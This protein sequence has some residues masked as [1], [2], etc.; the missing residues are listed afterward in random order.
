MN[1]WRVGFVCWAVFV[2]AVPG[3]ACV[4]T[5]VSGKHEKQITGEAVKLIMG[6]FAQHGEAYWAGQLKYNTELLK[7]EPGNPEH[8]NDLAVALLKLKRYDEA[9]AEFEKIEVANPGRYKT[10][11]NLG[12]LYK[13]T[14]DFQKAAEYTRKALE[15]KP[16][17]HLGLGDYYLQMLAW[18]A[19]VASDPG[20]DPA[21]N[22]LGI[23]Y[24]DGPEAVKGSK[25]VNVNYLK[26]LIISDHHFSD[27]YLV[28]G[29]WYAASEEKELAAR[30]YMRA[31]QFKDETS[32]P[33]EVIHSRLK[34]YEVN[35]QLF[36]QQQASAASWLEL[37]SAAEADLVKNDPEVDFNTIRK[38]MASGTEPKYRNILPVKKQ[39]FLSNLFGG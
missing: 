15:V 2:L 23:P 10:Y 13:K 32:T 5:K 27:V 24:A 39:G 25:A 38:G 37:F 6:Q 28:L 17:G 11:S 7:E 3:E 12:V 22:F 9:V 33:K 8:R 30:C 34:N 29:D 21:T 26:T 4:N 36:A 19:D 18:R 16:E 20:T 31:L 35:A 1:K 14:G